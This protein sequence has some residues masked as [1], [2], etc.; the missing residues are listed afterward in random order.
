MNGIAVKLDVEMNNGVEVRSGIKSKEKKQYLMLLKKL[1]L[2]LHVG[3]NLANVSL[4]L[5]V[6]VAKQKLHNK[7]SAEQFSACQFNVWSFSF[8][9]VQNIW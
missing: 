9:T 8:I 7:K 6:K 2:H 5:F 1:K 4:T 3:K